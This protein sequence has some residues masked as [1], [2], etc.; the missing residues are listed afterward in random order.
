MSLA[1]LLQGLDTT[2][3]AKITAYT[4]LSSTVEPKAFVAALHSRL[5]AADG[6]AKLP[7]WCLVDSMLKNCGPDLV[8]LLKTDVLLEC[9]NIPWDI[10]EHAPMY[11]AILQSWST[12]LAD[13]EYDEL[14]NRV[15]GGLFNM[16]RRQA[17]KEKAKLASHELEVLETRQHRFRQALRGGVALQRKKQVPLLVPAED[18]DEEEPEDDRADTA[19]DTEDANP[20]QGQADAEKPVLAVPV[21]A[22]SGSSIMS[23][24]TS[25]LPPVIRAIYEAPCQC[26]TTGVRFASEAELA[27]H[28]DR[29]FRLRT[30]DQK[31][32]KCRVWA[33]RPEAWAAVTSSENGGACLR[34]RAE[35]LSGQSS[36]GGT[37]D[38]Y[39]TLHSTAAVRKRKAE[40][41]STAARV[42]IADASDTLRCAVCAA[43]FDKEVVHGEWFLQDAVEMEVPEEG[44]PWIKITAYV[45]AGCEADMEPSAKRKKVQ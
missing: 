23:A 27:A 37:S 25:D 16:R 26:E 31:Y 4:L 33:S 41:A 1:K 5:K 9:L 39:D 11:V 14:V 18:K 44:R 6:D 43:A 21:A 10:R 45:H 8:L 24:D 7:F 17:A 40:E 38:Y 2:E 28:K 13:K 3:K 29:M 36:F 19:L 15:K 20:N 32:E 35:V 22:V 12:V 42:A 30:T 34:P